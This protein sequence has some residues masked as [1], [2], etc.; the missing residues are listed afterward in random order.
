MMQSLKLTEM[1]THCGFCLET[2]PT[3]VVTRNEVHSPRGRIEAVRAGINSIGFQT[4]MYCRLCETACPAGVK[5]GQIIVP[6]RKSD[7]KQTIIEK[8]LENPSIFSRVLKTMNRIDHPDI[9]RF[10]E[11][12]GNVE[13][14]S[15][16]E[17]QK[18]EGK[19]EIILFPGCIES[20]FFRRTV[21]KAFNYLSKYYK[22]K[23]IN[24]CC[25]LAHISNG[26]YK[27][28]ENLAKK[29]HEKIKDK[30]IVLLQSNC[31]AFMK[32]Y[33]ELFG[34]N[35]HVYDF[36]EFIVKE[37]LE[38]PRRE[39]V[40]TIHYPCHAYRQKLTR[41]IKEVSEKMGLEIREMEDPFFEC[42]AGGDYWLTHPKLSDMVRSVKREKIE[43]S[44]V[45][46]VIATNSICALSIRSM[47]FDVF[48]IA[49]FL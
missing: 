12:V 28:A 8:M 13:V 21:E 43:K 32:E 44:G 33:S 18:G 9:R 25:G 10:M 24:G 20:I 30:K 38:V 15:P 22:V 2:C 39:G 37:N 49:D 1:C 11:F 5:Y 41:Y 26:N 7:I 4:C 46:R 16:L 29:L 14:N 34:I 31:S 45:R 27:G 19:E 42:G 36:S 3:Y 6:Y 40:F 35:L 47:G 48:H 17:G 23:I